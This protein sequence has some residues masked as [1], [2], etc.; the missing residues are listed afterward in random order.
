M[1]A[2][3]ELTEVLFRNYIVAQK[4]MKNGHIRVGQAP[5]WLYWPRQEP[6]EA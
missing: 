2:A 3:P 1:V 4:L 5:G 6:E